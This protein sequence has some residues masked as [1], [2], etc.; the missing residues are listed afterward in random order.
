MTRNEIQKLRR[1]ANTI[2]A[3]EVNC[4]DKIKARLMD[5]LRVESDAFRLIRKAIEILEGEF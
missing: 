3:T 2:Q 4:S 5:E 1:I